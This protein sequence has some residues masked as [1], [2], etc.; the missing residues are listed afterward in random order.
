MRRATRDEFGS[1]IANQVVREQGPIPAATDR[2]MSEPTVIAEAAVLIRGGKHQEWERVFALSDEQQ[3]APE[4]STFFQ[5]KL[6]FARALRDAN[7]CDGRGLDLR[8]RQ[9]MGFYTHYHVTDASFW[10]SA[11]RGSDGSDARVLPGYGEVAGGVERPLRPGGRG[12]GY[13]GEGLPGRG[14]E[15]LAHLPAIPQDRCPETLPVPTQSRYTGSSSAPRES[16]TTK[17]R[18]WHLLPKAARTPIV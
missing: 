4:T 13:P 15:T 12:C 3:A 17:L 1:R 6:L 5:K 7:A 10:G 16:T 14:P 11:V 2:D 9:L 18:V 8:E